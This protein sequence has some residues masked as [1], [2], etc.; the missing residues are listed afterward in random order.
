MKIDVGDADVSVVSMT[1]LVNRLLKLYIHG[2]TSYSFYT[3]TYGYKLL[4]NCM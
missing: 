2:V 3:S 1:P 4:L